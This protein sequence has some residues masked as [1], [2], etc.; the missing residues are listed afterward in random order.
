MRDESAQ[1]EEVC[2][3]VLQAREQGSLLRDQAVLMRTSHDSDLLELELSRRGGG[4]A[5]VAL[6]GGGGQ[7]EALL[8]SR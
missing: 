8:L 1:A 6:C 4:R 3:R 7:G 2:T 5:A